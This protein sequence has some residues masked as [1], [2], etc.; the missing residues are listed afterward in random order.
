MRA[1]EGCRRR[2]IKCDAATTNS[3]PCAACIR[4]KLNCVPPTVSYDKDYNSGTQTFEL[5]PKPLEYAPPVEAHPQHQ[6][7]RHSISGPMPH[8]LQPHMTSAM[9]PPQQ[10]GY[11][12]NMRMYQNAPPPYID[13]QPQDL[14][15]YSAVP[16]GQVMPQNMGYAPQQVYDESPASAPP[17]S[18]SPPETESSWR[19]DSI[20]NLSDVMGELKIDHTAV[21]MVPV[22]LS[23]SDHPLTSLAPY[24][25]NQK[26]AL[27]EA[28]A[29]EEFEVQLPPSTSMDHT[30]RIPPEMMPS[31][32]Q[33]LQYFDYYFTN[34]H[35]YCPVINKAYFY[36]QWQTARDSISPL[37]LEAIFACATVM[38]ES[39]AEGNKWLAL[40]ASQCAPS[41][42]VSSL[43]DLHTRA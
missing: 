13:Q 11:V 6:F 34:I 24:I 43:A 2:K 12:D 4:L 32:E 3:W 7:Q 26:K 31:E 9:Q 27:A 29:Q 17:V 22:V 10:A 35:P 41:P 42:L 15:Q 5:E 16:Q 18:L 14:G 23:P 25:A 30:V 20:S 36:Q 1:C 33:A 8:G 19:N 39:V 21:G 38:L 40:A 28:P 37:M